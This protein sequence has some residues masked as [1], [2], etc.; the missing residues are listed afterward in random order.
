VW[1]AGVIVLLAA[2]AAVSAWLGRPHRPG[3]VTPPWDI[4]AVAATYT[5]IAGVLAGFAVTSTIFL[6]N[7]DAGA[8]TGSFSATM[9]MFLIAF[10]G[11]LIASQMFGTLPTRAAPGTEAEGLTPFQGL[12]FVLAIVGYYIGLSLSLLGLRPLLLVL[13]LELLAEV[14]VWLLLATVL[15]GAGRLGVFLYRLTRVAGRACL[16]V[17]GLGFSAAAVYWLVATRLAPGLWPAAEAPLLLALVLAVLAGL[18][19]AAETALLAFQGEPRLQRRRRG[20]ER[21]V[22]TYVQA[23]VTVAVLLWFAVA[24]G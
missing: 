8:E 20:A 4:A 23:V 12:G 9:G 1:L 15:G 11:F 21:A 22:L 17:P 3:V 18:G 19:F 2:V 24:T 10:V 16:A 6:A 5:G 14:F 7:L 13:G